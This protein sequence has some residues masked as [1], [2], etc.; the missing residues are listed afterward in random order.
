M[1]AFG[2]ASA[3]KSSSQILAHYYRGSHLHRLY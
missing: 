1:G 2:M 3:G